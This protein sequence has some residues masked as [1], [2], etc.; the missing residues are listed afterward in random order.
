M[1]LLEMQ[2]CAMHA[3]ANDAIMAALTH[4]P[5]LQLSQCSLF[6]M[7]QPLDAVALSSWQ[8]WD[9]T[10]RFDAARR[11]FSAWPTVPHFRTR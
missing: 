9:A 2:R 8:W 7:F 4:N 3:S 10:P 5:C 1:H 11:I 6:Y